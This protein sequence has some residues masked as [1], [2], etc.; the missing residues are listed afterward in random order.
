[1]CPI[2]PYCSSPAFCPEKLLTV[3]LRSSWLSYIE[4]AWVIHCLFGGQVEEMYME[5][6]KVLCAPHRD[7]FL[8]IFPSVKGHVYMWMD[9]WQPCLPLLLIF[10]TL[11]SISKKFFQCDHGEE[12]L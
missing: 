1:M 6:G 3:L 5:Q 4:Q 7:S 8:C 10:Y 2:S 12:E 9:C 11:I